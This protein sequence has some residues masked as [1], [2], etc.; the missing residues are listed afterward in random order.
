MRRR[1][2]RHRPRKTY[3]SEQKPIAGLI[4]HDIGPKLGVFAA[5]EQSLPQPLE[6]AAIGGEMSKLQTLIKNFVQSYYHTLPIRGGKG[7]PD[8]SVLGQKL[9]IPALSL[10]S[11]LQNP[12]T[13]IPAIRY[14]IAWTIFTRIGVV[15]ASLLPAEV[16]DCLQ[17]LC[18]DKTDGFSTSTL[19]VWRALTHYLHSK[20]NAGPDKAPINEGSTQTAVRDLESVIQP[21]ADAKHNSEERTAKLEAIIKRGASFGW[22]LFGQT[23]CFKFEWERRA[24]GEVCIFPSLLQTLD[25]NAKRMSGQGKWLCEGEHVEVGRI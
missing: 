17:L 22:T 5:V 6:D 12:K 10:E 8:L 14:C 15:N 25:E 21:Y 23:S 7:S 18:K 1:E 4:T 20:A 13:R 9:S 2:R 19:A 3:S 11:I 24:G 16:L